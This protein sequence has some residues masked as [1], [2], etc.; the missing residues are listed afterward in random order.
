MRKLVFTYKSIRL[1]FRKRMGTIFLFLLL[2]EMSCVGSASAG[3]VANGQV[4]NFQADL[5][6]INCV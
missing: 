2:L 5:G 4:R 6:L 1:S 3:K